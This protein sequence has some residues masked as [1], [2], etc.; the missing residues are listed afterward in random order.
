MNQLIAFKNTRKI[1]SELTKQHAHL[2]P[3]MAM[4]LDE[5]EKHKLVTGGLTDGF[6]DKKIDFLC[7]EKQNYA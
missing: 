5:A 6:M 7:S 3:S 1:I 4:Y 2:A